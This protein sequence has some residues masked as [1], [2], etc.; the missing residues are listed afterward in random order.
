[1]VCPIN[2][3]W[4][5]WSSYCVLVATH[6]VK[7]IFHTFI[8]SS[9]WSLSSNCSWSAS[10]SL[11]NWAQRSL[12]DRIISLQRCSK[13]SW[14]FTL[15]L[16]VSRVLTESS[17]PSTRQ[18]TNIIICTQFPKCRSVFITHIAG[19]SQ[20]S[21][22]SCAKSAKLPSD[23]C[24][25]QKHATH[26][27]NSKYSLLP[28]INLQNTSYYTSFE[29]IL[30]FNNVFHAI[31]KS[32]WFINLPAATNRIFTGRKKHETK[33]ITSLKCQAHRFLLS[34]GWVWR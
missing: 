34:Q 28:Q 17:L 9:S 19:N 26:T 29:T 11:V 22:E 6:K 23:Y 15:W 4:K 18:D 13:F 32:L 24:N 33:Q 5:Y 10:F 21:K 25:C 1:M 3:A 2:K 31:K 8:F 30:L 27:Q 7:S 16:R 14:R 12:C 20:V